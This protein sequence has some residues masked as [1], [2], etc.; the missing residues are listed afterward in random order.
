MIN[1][2]AKFNQEV[3]SQVESRVYQLL[4]QFNLIHHDRRTLCKKGHEMSLGFAVD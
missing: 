2:I 4:R 3:N 1:S